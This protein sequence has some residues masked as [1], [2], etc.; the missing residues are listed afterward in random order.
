MARN[1]CLLNWRTLKRYKDN[2]KAK[3]V[4]KWFQEVRPNKIEQ[5]HSCT[6]HI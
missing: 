3:F 6:Y 1:S 2:G 4:D 5:F